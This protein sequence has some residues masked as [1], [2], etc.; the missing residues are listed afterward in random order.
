MSLELVLVVPVLVLLAV[1]VLWAG[2][3]GR[4]ALTADLAAEE[5]VTAAA[6]CCEEDSGGAGGRE[7]LVEDMLEARP[8]LGFLCIGG[9]RP[10]AGDGGV[11]FLSE[12]WVE[13]E[14]GREIGGVGVLGVRFLCESD[15]AVAPLRGLF[16]TVTF[17]GQ[18]A[19]VVQRE[20]RFIVGFFP[21]RVEVEE[22]G[23]DTV[24]G[25]TVVVEPALGED[26]ELA[27][28][29]DWD[30]TTVEPEDFVGVTDLAV[31]LG[32]GSSGLG[33]V[34]IPA[35]EG[36]VEVVLP[37]VVDD[38]L[39]EG[40]EELV[41]ELTGADLPDVVLDEDRGIWTGVVGDNDPQPYLQIV[42]A[43]RVAEGGT[44]EFVVRVGVEEGGAVVGDIAQGFTVGVSTLDDAAAGGDC[45]VSGVVYP[46]ATAAQDYTSLDAMSTDGMLSFRRGG[47]LSVVV[48]VVTLDDVLSPVG[49]PTECVRLVLSGPSTEAPPLHSVRW[50][51]DGRIVDDEATVSVSDVTGVDAAEGESVVFRVTLDKE[52]AADVTLGYTLGPDARP[53]AHGATPAAGVSCA[54]GVDYLGATGQVTIDALSLEATFEV[55]TCEDVL[56]ERGETFWVGLSRDGGEVVVPPRTGAHGTIRDDDVPVISVSPATVEGTEGDRLAFTVGLSVGGDP[57]QLSEDMTVAYGIGGGGSDPATAPGEPGEDYGVTLDTAALGSALQGTLAFTAAT[58]GTEY[59]FEVELLADYLLEDPESFVLRLSDGDPSDGW[60]LDEAVATGTI[61]DDAPPVLSVDD[62][63]GPEGTTQSFTISLS[64]ARAGETVTVDYAIVGGPGPGAATAPGSPDP[65]FEPVPD[66]GP[67]TAT[68]AFGPLAPCQTSCTVEVSLLA[69]YVPDEGDETLRL[70]LTNPSGAVLF[71]HDPVAGGVQAYGVGTITDDAPP[72]LSVSGFRGP[73]DSTQSFKV[74]LDMAPRAGD[75][76][77]VDYA[78]TGGTGAGQATE[79]FDYEA[80]LGSALSGTLSFGAGVTARSVAVTLLPD[81]VLDGGETL[82]IT[83]SNAQHAYL[84]STAATATGTID[85]VDSPLLTVDNPN[86]LEGD[87]MTFTVTLERGRTGDDVTVNYT[88]EPKEA[89]ECQVPQGT[90]DPTSLTRSRDCEKGTG[91]YLPVAPGELKLDAANPTATV[92]VQTLTDKIAENAETLHLVLSGPM[93]T[94]VGLGNAVGVGTIINVNPATVRVNNPRIREGGLLEFEISLVDDGNQPASIRQDVTVEFH[95]ADRTAGEGSACTAPDADYLAPSGPSVTFAPGGQ[96]EHPVRVETCPDTRDEDDETVALVLAVD[97]DNDAAVLGDSEGTG[98]IEDADPPEIRIAHAD[99][100]EGQTLT[101]DVT[102]VDSNGVETS[103]SEVV[104]VFAATED[105]T[106]HAG[107]D[108]TAESRLLTIPAGDTRVRVP[109]EFEVATSL[110]DINEPP[111]TFGVVLSRA[112]NAKIDR[113]VAVGTINPRCVDASLD[114]DNNRPPTITLHDTTAVEGSSYS[115]LVTFSAPMCEAPQIVRQ[116]ISGEGLGTATCG[117]DFHVGLGPCDPPAEV[118]GR[119]IQAITTVPRAQAGGWRIEA[120]SLDE[121]DE[122]FTHRWRW[123]PDMPAHYQWPGPGLGWVSAR[124]TILDDDPLPRLSVADASADEGDAVAFSISLDRASGRPVTVRYQT[125]AVTATGGT[126]YTEVDDTHT[127]V[128]GARFVTVYVPTVDDGAGDSGETFLFEVGAPPDPSTPMNAEIVDGVAVGTILEGNLPEMRIYDASADEDT[129]MLDT[130]MFLRVEL[131]EAAARTVTVDYSTVERSGP[132]AA[133]EGVDYQPVV[134]QQLEFAPGDTVKFAEVIVNTDTDPEAAET[135]LVELADPSGAELADPSAVGTINS[136]VTCYDPTEPGAVAPRVTVDSPSAVESD[137]QITF[138][139]QLSE[140]ICYDRAVFSIYPAG[141]FYDNFGSALPNV[142]FHYP[143]LQGWTTTVAALA[144]EASFTVVLIDD[145]IDE[146]DEDIRMSVRS[147]SYLEHVEAV[148]T[149]VDDDQAALSVAGDSGPEGGFLNFVIRLDGPSDRTVTVDYATEDA[150]PPSAEAGTDYRARSDTAVIAAGDLSATVAVFA[151]QDRL[152]EDAET[153]QLRLSNPTG[154][155]SLADADAVATGTITDDDDPPAVTVSNPS[156]DEGGKLVFAVTLDAPSGRTGSVS[157]STRDGGVNGGATAVADYGFESGGLDFDI[158]E[159]FKTVAVQSFSDDETEG[160]ERFFLDLTSSDFGFDKDI[161][162]GIIRDVT[163]RRVSVSDAVAVEGGV[164]RFVV[165]FDGPPASRDITVRYET[166]ADTAAARADYSDAVESAPGVVRIL[167]GRTSAVVGVPTVQDTLDED[168]EQL[169]LVLSDPAGAV[170]ASSEAVGTIIDDDPEPLLSVDDPEA[171]ENGDG[172]PVVF[173]LRLSEVSGR[174]VSVRHITVDSTA[175]AG[176][177]YVAVPN[178]RAPIPAGHRTALVLVTLVDDDVEEEV[179]RFRL[180]LSD[181]SNARFGDS[182][183]AATILDDDAPPQVFIDDAAA[184]YEAAG[185][186]VSFAVRLNRAD[187]DNAVT[188][189]YATEDATALAGDDYAHTSDTLMFAAGDI[190][191]TVTVDLVDDDAAEDT[192]TFRLRLSNPSSNATVGNDDSAVA[193]ILDDD[194]LPGLSVAD[195]PVAAEGTTATFSVELSRSSTQEVTVAYAAVADPFGGDAAAIPG[196]DFTAVAGTLAIPARSTSATVTVPLPDDALDEHTETFWLRLANPTGAIV[197]DGTGIGTI[198]DDDPLPQLNIADSGATEGDTVR[199]TVTLDTASG[200]TVMVPWT[201]APSFTGDPASPTE[202]FAAA[203]GTLTFPSGTT[204][205]HIDITTVDD[206]VS[207]PDETFQIQLGQP[208]N[209]TV[210][211]GVAVGAI[212]DDDSLPRISIAGTELLETDGPA[213]FVVTLSSLSSRPVTVDYATAEV[214]AAAGGPNYDYGPPDG[215]ATGTLVI[216][217]GLD[218]GEISVYVADDGEGEQTETF[219]ITLS[220]AQNAVIAEG[221]GT[222]VGTILDDDVTRIAIGDA[223]AYE[224]DGTIE[225]PLTLSPASAGQVTVRYTTFDGSAT[226]PADYT[227]ATGTLTIPAAATAATISVNLTDDSFVEDPESFLLRLHDPTGVEI[228]AADAV[229][230]IL[231]DDDLP[232]IQA[233]G[234]LVYENDGTLTYVVELDKASD[235]VVTVDY[236]TQAEYNDSY[237]GNCGSMPWE[238]VSGTL[239]FPVGSRTA[240]VVV[241]LIDNVMTCDFWALSLDLTDPVNAV[242]PSQDNRSWIFNEGAMTHVRLANYSNREIIR[243]SGDSLRVQISAWPPPINDIEITYRIDSI[244]SIVASTGWGQFQINNKFFEYP[245]SQYAEAGSDF[246]IVQAGT[247]T[248]TAGEQF[249]H[250][251]VEVLDDNVVEPSEYF[252]IRLTARDGDP[253]RIDYDTVIVVEIVDDDGA[254][255]SAENIETIESSATAQFRIALD[256]PSTQQISVVYETADGSATAPDDYTHT[257]GTLNIAAGSTVGFVDVPLIDDDDAESDE[258]F[259]LRL[260]SASSAVIVDDAATAT[261]RDDDGDDAVPVLTVADAQRTED[262][263][264]TGASVCFDLTI[265]PAMAITDRFEVTYQFIEAPWLGEYAAEA[266]TDFRQDEPFVGT[267]WPGYTNVICV[268]VYADHIP[269]RDERF[270]LW[271]SDPN[272]VVLGNSRAWGTILNNDLPIIS[273]DDVTVFES[274]G[275]AEFTLSLHEPGLAPA[276]VRYTT[277]PRPSEGDAAATP[278]DD[279]IHTAG[280]LTIPAGVTTTTVRVSIIPDSDDELDETFL[281]ELSDPDGLA[282]SKSAAVGTIT[283]DDDGWTIDDRSVREDAGSMV[284]TVIRDHTSTSAAILNYTVTGASAVGGASCTDAGVDYITPS[285]SVTLLPAETQAEISVQICP[286]DVAEGSETLLIELTG[287]PGRKLTGTGTIVDDGS[288]G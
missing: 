58:P 126:D 164:L 65:D 3:G 263:H 151:P 246:P 139:V 198:A 267:L 157:Y 44:L 94:H 80:A 4:A 23:S 248:I 233:V 79:D 240:T 165:D 115:V 102:L 27:Y 268:Y 235:R 140:P 136:D 91:D 242:V 95:T 203:S 225:F 131:S 241:T 226:Q 123:G 18:A 281:L 219:H 236:A 252:A 41:L 109:F 17:H 159:T 285:G 36:S 20:P 74:E 146:P 181:P 47:P 10:N 189:D 12:E 87:A 72:V 256:R 56:V 161:G 50:K 142:D 156:A 283:D 118:T 218:T 195:A 62:F 14:P 230:V 229:G 57:A 37:M 132:R 25:F 116:Q 33:T 266:G 155:A 89:T 137:G 227:A 117:V 54:D 254:S 210:D 211:D 265:E 134:R 244:P 212:V 170:L 201:T 114:D 194:G 260:R 249:A 162:T 269:E 206:E 192:E 127:F 262:G 224:A 180:E 6:L 38:G 100:E 71:D 168:L 213:V 148:G 167:A 120:D 13:F 197:D 122:W 276:T 160:S 178:G 273:V 247:V 149:I 86:A 274:D 223:D 104:T 182:I 279:Y 152:D 39:F 133:A 45:L 271:L 287:V 231:D 83:L 259:E 130:T 261:I 145:D 220:N 238:P 239:T 85:D 110:D 21:T 46:W 53:G 153:F 49:E 61:L 264:P 26:V 208:A 176:D 35:G 113:A 237:G 103:T 31:L 101:F 108:Y 169:T 105:G 222:A 143:D 5:A 78:I 90:L 99:A 177:D 81:A 7:A 28:E 9:P 24:L 96:T 141:I 138:T 286:D 22:G 250:F 277:R 8:G 185:A 191:G 66:T 204:T 175:K 228:A 216:P 92:S 124:V 73:E 209:A 60:M 214:T 171:T 251:P 40:D 135:F 144:T 70:T 280:Q 272:G 34:V 68:V 55:Q 32:L 63:T 97:P 183:G 174:D 64:D 288:G 106:A 98:T 179:E 52:P 234:A 30:L 278:G 69:D 84:D 166:V 76:V 257:S 172:T 205:A 187:P 199:F 2:R 82:T 270:I 221:A 88:V 232:V 154:G 196:Q 215:E 147:A 11:G 284:F 111:E 184:T 128:P 193:T 15:G 19:E 190:A 255:V 43:P 207:E 16:P 200:R 150:T 59:V 258:T 119:L 158:G 202:D 1:F 245:P 29:V 67:L 51:A 93:P 42:G 48:P 163:Q 129:T 188:V 107:A 243:E 282:F 77:M 125:V 75:T 112:G 186:S 173:T 121:D 217:A 253:H 275:F